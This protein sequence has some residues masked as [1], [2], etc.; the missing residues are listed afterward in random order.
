M[1]SLFD[2]IS[3]V[4]PVDEDSPSFIMAFDAVNFMMATLNGE[5]KNDLDRNA[6][7]AILGV[8]ADYFISSGD[9]EAIEIYKE[10]AIQAADSHSRVI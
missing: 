5:L 4:K 6:L 10:L 7:A 9:E 8:V 2:A 3:T 1:K